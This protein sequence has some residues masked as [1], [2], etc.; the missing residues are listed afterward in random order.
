MAFN[1]DVSTDRGKVRLIISDIDRDN[2]IFQDDEIDAF[3]SMALNNN[4]KRAAAQ[5]LRT[6]AANENYVQKAI[7]ILDL[8]TDGPAVAREFRQ[9]ANLLEDQADKE[10]SSE[11]GASFDWAE[12]VTTPAQYDERLYKEALR[13][14]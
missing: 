11:E 10:E 7:R 2:V 1:Y 12:L 8:Q 4:L 14:N 3:I 5:A 13:D 9:Q 6:I